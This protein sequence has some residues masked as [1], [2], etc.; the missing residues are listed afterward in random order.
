MNSSINKRA[1]FIR[2]SAIENMDNLADEEPM[3][4]LSSQSFE[5][6]TVLVPSSKLAMIT[7]PYISMLEKEKEMMEEMEKTK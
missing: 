3:L 7:M 6:D 2:Y 1:N 4:M 5:E